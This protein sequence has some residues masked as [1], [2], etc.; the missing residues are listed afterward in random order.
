[1]RCGAVNRSEPHRTDRQNPDHLL[2]M[3]IIFAPWFLR[4]GKRHFP[5]L[6]FI[7]IQTEWSRVL[8]WSFEKK[9]CSWERVEVAEKIRK[10]VK[11]TYLE[12]GGK[13]KT[14]IVVVSHCHGAQ[15][16]QISFSNQGAKVQSRKIM[17]FAGTSSYNIAA[18]S[19][20][21]LFFNPIYYFRPFL[22]SFLPVV[23]QSRGHIFLEIGPES[24]YTWAPVDPLSDGVWVRVCMLFSTA[25]WSFFLPQYEP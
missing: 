21:F 6:C 25:V 15:P 5:P 12:K 3:A 10:M 4:V 2:Y 7:T 1:M 8:L 18:S 22:S 14:I 20:F 19:Q 24:P 17:A 13:E 9:M 11:Y 16:C 23:T